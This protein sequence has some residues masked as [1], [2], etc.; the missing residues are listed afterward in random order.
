MPRSRHRLVDGTVAATSACVL[1]AGMA[2]MND[3]VR[4][5]IVNVLNGDHSGQLSMLGLRANT[6]AGPL[7]KMAVDSWSA[8]TPLVV[9]GLASIVLV[10]FMLRT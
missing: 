2:A 9:F 4:G 6:L 3:D 10:A 1:F 7:V 8:H 5:H